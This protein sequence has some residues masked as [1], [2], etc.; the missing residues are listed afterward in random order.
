MIPKKLKEIILEKQNYKCLGDGRVIV[1]DAPKLR[2]WHKQG[3]PY[4]IPKEYPSF[5][6]FHHL[7]PKSEGGSDSASNIIATCGRCH[8]RRHNYYNNYK[9]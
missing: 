9:K 1:L 2:E 8:A 5:A 3:I 7:K 4:P 6:Y